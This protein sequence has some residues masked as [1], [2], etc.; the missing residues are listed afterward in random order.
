MVN[1]GV[2][3]KNYLVEKMELQWKHPFTGMIAGP[4]SC[5]KSTFTTRFLKHLGTVTDTV[6]HEI[7]YCAPESSYPDLSECK[8]PVKFMDC[9]PDVEMFTD[10]RPRV[11]ILDDM[12]RESDERV[13]DLFTKVKKH[14]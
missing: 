10:K 14:V 6:F 5:G 1:I 7:V 11:I 12:M 13:V 9:I 8:T 2:T 4:T 3:V